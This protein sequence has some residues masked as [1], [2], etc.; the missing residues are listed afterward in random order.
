MQSRL[1]IILE[2]VD[3]ILETRA[4]DRRLRRARQAA[5]GRATIPDRLLRLS[6]E[7]DPGRRTYEVDHLSHAAREVA[8]NVRGSTERQTEAGLLTRL[9]GEGRGEEAQQ[10]LDIES[11]RRIRRS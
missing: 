8:M 7:T 9:R 4:K 2:T 11:G 3:M 5:Q 1:D 10:I 6:Y